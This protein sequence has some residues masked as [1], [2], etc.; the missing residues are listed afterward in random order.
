[1]DRVW[2]F[3]KSI[4]LKMI[5]IYILLLLI[6]IQVIG[7]YFAEQLENSLRDN[8]IESVND[9]VELLTY[10][11]E[12]AFSVERTEETVSLRSDVGSIINNF[13]SEDINTIQVIN[14]NSRVIGTTNEFD[15][16]NVGK[17]TTE[18]RIQRALSGNQT[19]D[20]V[21]NP[22]NGQRML[23][24]S[25]PIYSHAN[26]GEVVGALHIQ[27]SLE[28]VY[29]QMNDINQ[30]FAN[31]TV[32]AITISALL[33]IL[34]ARTVT[35]PITEMR[36][37]AKVM[38][39]GDF[40]QKVNVYGE[41]EIGQLAETFNEMNDK[42]Q[43]AQ[44]SKESERRKLSLVLTNMTDGVI[45][46]NSQGNII[47]TNPPAEDLI[48][49]PF[50]EVNQQP[51][52]KVLGL[53]DEISDI[54][55]LTDMRSTILDFSDDHHHLLVRAGFSEVEDEHGEM[56]GI[57]TVLGDVTEQEEIER[58]RRE[59]VANV[60][61]ELRTP[62]TT[63]RSYLE[64]LTD[65]STW[66]DEQIAPKFLSVTQNETERMIRLVNDLLQLSKMD[67]KDY[68]LFKEQVNYI[69]FIHHVV[70]RF[71]LNLKE[72][73]T[74][75]RNLP[76]SNYYVWI[77]KDKV[78]Q[79]LDNIISNAIKYSPEGGEILVEVVKRKHQL[80]TKITDQGVGIPEDNL[81]K[82]FNRF[83]RVD[84]ARSRQLGGT[85]L[86]LA[87][88]K[89]LIEAHDGEVWADS[90]ESKGTTITF[91]LPLMQEKRGHRS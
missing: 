83:Y 72:E 75:H 24:L 44:A 63:M 58:E 90:E 76:D 46:T 82:I 21:Y 50:S 11:L 32:L 80:L 69:D 91:R 8:F 29:G 79:V 77:D 85:G 31:G 49:Q 30:I 65:G 20:I 35:K 13:D 55:E 39:A 4:Q 52:I 14:N 60:S 86:G 53:D 78:I 54:S 19:E 61:H 15:Q 42:I 12:Q 34:V 48:N 25:A 6:A 47:L 88:A 2:G 74:I 16:I 66:K 57:I 28:G 71:E 9:R 62:L 41:D 36:K 18:L 22:E 43:A 38:G 27:A 73:I 87:I 68:Q 23:V 40:S 37:Q 89:E 26:I 7:A 81:E 56:S 10:N 67:N 3:F 17:R 1:M 64:A 5:L 45:A 51:L 59:F 70:D 84:K 33:G